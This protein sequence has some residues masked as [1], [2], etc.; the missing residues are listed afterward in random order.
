MF[1]LEIF[2][3]A[4]DRFPRDRATN[5]PIIFFQLFKYIGCTLFS[6][7]ALMLIVNVGKETLGSLRP[8]F[9]EACRPSNM[10]SAQYQ[11][12]IECTND[13]ARLVEEARVSFPSGHSAAMAWGAAMTVVR[14]TICKL[15]AIFI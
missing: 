7:V 2:L 11:P 13:D 5:I 1:I 10:N 6:L 3:A 14:L 8:F 4:K 9:L 15:N 12:T